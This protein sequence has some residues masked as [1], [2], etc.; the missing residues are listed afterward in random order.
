MPYVLCTEYLTS[1]PC[2]DPTRNRNCALP[3]LNK[4]YCSAPLHATLVVHMSIL[5][6]HTWHREPTHSSFHFFSA[7]RRSTRLP[8]LATALYCTALLS[9]N[10]P[11][12][13]SN[14]NPKAS[15]CYSSPNAQPPHFLVEYRADSQLP[16]CESVARQLDS[17]PLYHGLRRRTRN[18]HDLRNTQQPRGIAQPSSFLG[19][20]NRYIS[21]SP[22]WQLPQSRRVGALSSSRLLPASR[23]VSITCL[24]RERM[25]LSHRKLPSL[26]RLLPRLPPRTSK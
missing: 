25:E 8:V 23:P 12:S 26:L 22:S 11:T 17:L 14:T 20:Q 6:L 9:R 5:C 1:L 16:S 13:F 21:R 2:R 10:R 19:I 7:D 24:L 3:N 4:R 15:C 18:V